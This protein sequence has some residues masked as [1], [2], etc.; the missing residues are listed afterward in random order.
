MY[1]VTINLT[2]NFSW[3]IYG[4]IQVNFYIVIP[5][6]IGMIF[7]FILL[8]IGKIYQKKKVIRNKYDINRSYVPNITNNKSFQTKNDSIGWI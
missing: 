7:S 2:G 6:F 3:V 5:N 1:L 4:F 8:F